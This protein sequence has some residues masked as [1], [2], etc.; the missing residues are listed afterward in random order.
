FD[1]GKPQIVT[2]F[3]VESS[4]TPKNIPIADQVEAGLV[5]E[6][7][8]L[9][10]EAAHRHFIAY[11]FDDLHSKPED[12]ILARAAAGQHFVRSLDPATR[13]AI[14]TTSG[15][16]ISEFTGDL[17]A[18]REALLKI[19]SRKAT[20]GISCPDMGYFSADAVQNRN[21]TQVKTAL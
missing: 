19:Q 1:K 20:K 6:K 13:V 10:S 14:Y 11:L 5:E 15:L 2:K 8:G 17:V 18:L 7:S 4:R 9:A 16:T 21:D 3:S 12:L